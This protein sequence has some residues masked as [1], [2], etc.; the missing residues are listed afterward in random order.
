MSNEEKQ[1]AINYI[2]ACL[3]PTS[4]DE[5]QRRKLKYRKI[6]IDAIEKQIPKMVI[7]SGDGYA[8]GKM[9]YD[10]AECPSCGNNDYE[11][12]VSGWGDPYCCKCGQALQ[13]EVEE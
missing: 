13:W 10:M 9:V 1:R 5:D 6:A 11:Y 7:L 12:E 8:D 4:D 2:H 3:Q